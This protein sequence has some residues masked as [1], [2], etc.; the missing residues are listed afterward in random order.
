MLAVKL[1]GMALSAALTS[2]GGAFFAMY[3][4]FIDPP[5]LFSL[6]DV[7]LRFTLLALIGGIGT[8]AIA[9]LWMKLFPTLRQVE[10]LE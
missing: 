7:G 10:R 1:K 9:L 8:V 4:R 5:S 6:M 3:L 2:C